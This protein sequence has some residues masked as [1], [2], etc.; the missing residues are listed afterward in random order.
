MPR[1][2][3]VTTNRYLQFVVDVAASA[4]LTYV[5][6]AMVWGIIAEGGQGAAFAAMWVPGLLALVLVTTIV[7]FAVLP[8]WGVAADR[9]GF[10]LGPSLQLPMPSPH[11]QFAK[12]KMPL[13][14]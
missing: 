3:V 10:V 4:F 9:W 8:I 2:F 7:P 13:L 11:W 5:L 6:S 12:R 14:S 1:F